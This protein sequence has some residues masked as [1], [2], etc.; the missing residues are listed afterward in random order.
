[1]D[2]FGSAT[3]SGLADDFG[4]P[5]NWLLRANV[6]DGTCMPGD[7]NLDGEV[8]LLDVTPFVDAVTNA[9]TQCEADVNQDGFVDL[10]DVTPFVE[11]LSGG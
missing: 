11:L 9:S 8:N 7:V 10:L 6:S 3:L 5:G 4:F 1:M 2:P